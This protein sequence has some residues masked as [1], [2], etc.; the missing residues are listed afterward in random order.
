MNISSFSVLFNVRASHNSWQSE[1]SLSNL[2]TH[3]LRNTCFAINEW[4]KLQIDNDTLQIMIS[5]QLFI[6]SANKKDTTSLI[7]CLTMSRKDFI[8]F[9]ARAAGCLSAFVLPVQSYFLLALLP[10]QNRNNF[11]FLSHCDWYG[12]K[13]TLPCFQSWNTFETLS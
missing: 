10:E 13:L 5:I 11:I 6:R 9:N 12:Q 4:K 3:Y 8:K 2:I 1:K 7:C